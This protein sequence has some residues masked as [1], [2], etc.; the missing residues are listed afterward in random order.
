VSAHIAQGIE[1]HRQSVNAPNNV[2][3]VMQY[4][5]YLNFAVACILSYQPRGYQRYRHH[6]VEDK[7]YRLKRLDLG[8]ILV[9]VRSGALPLFHAIISEETLDKREF[10]LNELAV[11]IPYLSVE[12]AGIFGMN[13]QRIIVDERVDKR[14]GKCTSVVQFQSFDKSFQ[15]VRLSQARIERAMPALRSH[16]R[17]EDSTIDKRSYR[18]QTEWL[19]EER[20]LKWHKN[21]CMKLVNFGGHQFIK[22]PP[23]GYDIRCEYAWSGAARK[24]LLP[25]LTGALL[26]QTISIYRFQLY[27]QTENRFFGPCC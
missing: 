1:F 25:A 19:S 24:R 2:R 22:G 17:C 5:S 27:N 14:N 16:Y 13:T 7:S 9:R 26:G 10:R 6:G 18:S 8:S 21:V 12:L 15:A 3:P 23:I 11:A 20:A 4:Y